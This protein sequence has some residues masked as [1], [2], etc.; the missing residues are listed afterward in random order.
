M[1]FQAENGAWADETFGPSLS[2]DSTIAHLKKEVEELVADPSN[3]TEY[4]DCMILLIDAARRVGITM[5]LL[6]DHCWAKLEINIRR[7]W[8]PPD[9]DGIIEHI[10]EEGK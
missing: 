2:P 4:A 9:K 6:L 8:G 7:K 10:K 1:Y 5:D 3:V